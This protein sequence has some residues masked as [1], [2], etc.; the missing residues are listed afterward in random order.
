MSELM[1]VQ[2]V[3]DIVTF[4]SE[5][6][7]RQQQG[8][9]WVGYMV[10]AWLFMMDYAFVQVLDPSLIL[11]IGKRVEPVVN[12]TGF[13]DYP[14]RVGGN[15]KPLIRRAEIERAMLN[16]TEAISEQRIDA[17]TAYEEYEEIHPFGDGNGRT[18]KILYNWMKGTMWRPEFPENR[19]GWAIP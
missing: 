5:E 17:Q 16:L 19:K 3:R 13:R 8:P 2:N 18:G 12:A 15:V 14:V 1:Q 10:D 11:E 4:C 6:V 7:R 9:T